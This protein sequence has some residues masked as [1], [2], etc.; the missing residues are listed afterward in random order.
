MTVVPLGTLSRN[1]TETDALANA[2]M[3][4]VFG[5]E[6]VLFILGIAIIKM[7]PT[8]GVS[9][10]L[11]GACG[12]QVQ[13]YPPSRLTP[14]EFQ[15]KFNIYSLLGNPRKRLLLVVCQCSYSVV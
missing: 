15:V 3:W 5:H 8:A 13:L 14:K 9:G 1:Q 11:S 6:N 10:V 4:F 2:S 7:V 12:M